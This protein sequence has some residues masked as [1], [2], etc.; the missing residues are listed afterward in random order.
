MNPDKPNCVFPIRKLPFWHHT[1]ESAHCNIGNLKVIRNILTLCRQHRIILAA[2]IGKYVSEV[3]AALSVICPT[4]DCYPI[5]AV[6]QDNFVWNFAIYSVNGIYYTELG[7]EF[8][9]FLSK[10]EGFL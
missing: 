1:A 3:R 10:F 5:V 4:T 9:K 8:T 6:A 7:M 2:G